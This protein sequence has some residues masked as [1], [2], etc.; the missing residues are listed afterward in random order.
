[1]VMAK[2]KELYYLW[3]EYLKRSKNFRLFCDRLVESPDP[4]MTFLDITSFTFNSEMFSSPEKIVSDLLFLWMNYRKF[5]DVFRTN[6]EDWWEL[7]QSSNS[8]KIVEDLE[9]IIEEEARLFILY[10]VNVFK[11]AGIDNKNIIELLQKYIGFQR[12]YKFVKI[13]I[14]AKDEDIRNS[15]SRIISNVKKK[16]AYQLP[17]L[18]KYLTTFDLKTQGKTDIQIGKEIFDCDE[19]GMN[20]FYRK[21]KEKSE[22]MSDK[23]LSDTIRE[24]FNKAKCLI[25]N[26]EK[27]N[28]PGD[29]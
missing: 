19:T 24:Y 5:G 2:E 4:E 20:N 14:S 11:V 7:S 22:P 18:K 8:D 28:F 9:D 15:V 27:C 10:C 13:R 3:W 16:H 25:S 29:Y 6:F 21:N 26:A 23:E 17:L 12:D 1:M